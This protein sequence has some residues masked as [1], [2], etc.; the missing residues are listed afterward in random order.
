MYDTKYTW[1][2]SDQRGESYISLLI[3]NPWIFLV[4]KKEVC[5][6]FHNH[7][8]EALYTLEL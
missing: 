6:T 8:D 1:L 4:V 3:W 7:C 2:I 5:I